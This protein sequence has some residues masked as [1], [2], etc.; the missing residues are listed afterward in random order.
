M[1]ILRRR[2]TRFSSGKLS[3]KYH[4]GDANARDIAIAVAFNIHAAPAMG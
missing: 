4:C 3:T 1:I 2:A